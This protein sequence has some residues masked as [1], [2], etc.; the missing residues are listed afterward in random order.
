[1]GYPIFTYLSFFL[2]FCSFGF[3]CVS[4]LLR[5]LVHYFDLFVMLEK[6][7]KGYYFT[8]VFIDCLLIQIIVVIRVILRGVVFGFLSTELDLSDALV[9]SFYAGE[10]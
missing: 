3:L 7:L 6:F 4:F 5:L 10:D 2:T 8:N 9:S 1:M